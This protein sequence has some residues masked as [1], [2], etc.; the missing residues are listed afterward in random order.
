MRAATFLLVA[1]AA[2]A[3]RA[4]E[5]APGAPG[6]EAVPAAGLE[7]APRRGTFVETSLGAFTTLGGSRRFS[8]V[9][10]YLGLTAGRHMGGASSLFVSLGV[11]ASSDS[12]FQLAPA[13]CAGSDSFGVTFLEAGGALGLLRSDRLA[14]ALEGVAG[15]TLFS[16]SPFAYQDGR[17]ADALFAPHAGGGLSLEYDTH[18]DHFAVGFDALMRFTFA[19][20]PDG[21]GRATIPSLALLPRVRYVF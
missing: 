17:V 15:G 6:R 12:C 19:N 18:L 1:A 3:A 4:A 5:P 13:G 11:G 9:Q 14:F 2:A 7:E 8:V 20:R 21:S 16:S 10:P